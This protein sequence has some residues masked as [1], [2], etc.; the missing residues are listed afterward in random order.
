[1]PDTRTSTRLGTEA[2]VQPDPFL[3]RAQGLLTIS[4][5]AHA[6]FGQWQGVYN[7]IAD[8]LRACERDARRREREAEQRVWEEAQRKVQALCNEETKI[9]V[10]DK[11][12]CDHPNVECVH[13]GNAARVADN[14]R[15]WCRQQAKGR[16]E[17]G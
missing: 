5:K 8:E 4:L 10:Q 16:E 1:M 2:Q 15:I 13:N 17:E 9:Y 6:S 12:G 3:V 7:A 11:T 14:F